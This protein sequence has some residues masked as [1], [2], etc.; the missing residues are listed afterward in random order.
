M[1]FLLRLISSET[2]ISSSL[3][4]QWKT[5]KQTFQKIQ[6]ALDALEVDALTSCLIREIARCLKEGRD[7]SLERQL[8]E[9]MTI[10]SLRLKSVPKE[11]DSSDEE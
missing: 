10:A 3:L 9:T 5:K 1:V 11:E 4:K 7:H 8:L 6:L 2:F